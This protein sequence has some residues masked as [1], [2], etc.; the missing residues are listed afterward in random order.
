MTSGKHHDDFRLTPAIIIRLL[1]FSALFYGLFLYFSQK[2]K[3]DPLLL[4]PTLSVEELAS[5]DFIPKISQII[6]ASVIIDLT[7]KINW[8]KAEIGAFPQKQID[9]IK[10][11]VIQSI[12]DDLM[13][14]N[15]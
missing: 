10:R 4:D 12:Y 5:S 6:P 14:N 3:S 7:S 15:P 8:L 1:I 13:K 2:P 9:E 11:F